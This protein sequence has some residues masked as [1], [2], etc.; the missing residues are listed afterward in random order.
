MQTSFT[1]AQL[2]DPDIAEADKILRACVHCGFCNAT[3]PT[4]VLLGDERDGPRGRI[5]L[6]KDMLENGRPATE[7][8][9]RHID[10][11][12]SCLACMTTCPSGVHYMHLVDHA[13]A[14]VEETYERP[15]LDRVMRAFLAHVMPYPRRLRLASLASIAA[16]PLAPLFDAFGLKPLAAAIRL[17]PARAPGPFTQSGVHPAQ[18]PRRARVALLSGCANEALAP[19]I[20]QAAIR[21]LNRHG[22][23]VVIAPGEGCCGSLAHHM[24]REHDSLALART[25]VDAWT[26]E[27][28]GQGLDAILVAISGCG[29][30]VK[31][32]GFMLRTDESYKDKAA[33]VSA[34]ARDVSEYLATLAIAKAAAPQ[35]LTVAFHSPCSLQHGQRVHREPKDLLTA[36][37]FVVKEVPEAHLCCGSA[38]T[39]NI[40]QPDIA[41]RLRDRKIGNIEQAAPDVIAAGNIGC[42]TQ[43]ASGTPIPVV[44]PVE[45]LDWATGGPVP[46]RLRGR[47]GLN[48]TS[49][50]R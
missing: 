3:C 16:K 37:G 14:H 13:R 34:L 24:G 40:L 45:L 18:G 41:V 23:E 31:D 49:G 38:G 5:Y 2:A 44:H 39:Y 6:M 32:Y 30:T 15:W 36:C 35:K 12:L 9:V 20:T 43:I 11:C 17:A 29:T 48:E 28:E 1:L 21:V 46:E 47:M 26:R 27:I 10:R 4:Y 19:E 7:E 33:K 42:M 25:N 50:R 8:V 22:V